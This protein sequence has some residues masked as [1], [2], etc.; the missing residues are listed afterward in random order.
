MRVSRAAVRRVRLEFRHP[1]HTARGVATVRDTVLFAL[2]DAEGHTGHGEAAPW[3][4]FG[5]E[6]VDS[7]QAALEDVAAL[8]AGL[9][10]EPDAASPAIDARLRGAPAARAALEGALWDLASR[11]AGEPLA[12]SL[13]R[14][15]Q[16]GGPGALDAVATHALLGGDTPGA[17]R[18]SAAAARAAGYR[19]AKI[20]LGLGTIDEDVSRA[21]AAREALGPQLRLR[22]DANGAWDA[23]AA[24][25]A[26]ER[27]SPFGFEFVE[28]PLPAQALD[29]LAGLRRR[30]PVRIALDE[31]VATGPE[32][33]RAV[34]AGAADVLVL[35]PAFL[36]G[37]RRALEVAAR[38]RAAGVE[39]VFTHA[40]E[41][42]VGAH[43]ALHCAA[44]AADPAAIHGLGTAGLF[45]EDVAAPVDAVR[46]MVRVP[47]SPGL[48]VMP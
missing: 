16:P 17:V 29:A 8:V 7:A 19:A 10:L 6:D 34:E 46:G 24:A 4:G 2:T 15:V 5:T 14:A 31:S 41:S 47:V 40:M 35:K 38:A 37:P 42:A 3:P 48:G 18:K 22:G 26:L 27:L 39:V 45:A 25:D 9:D 32:A 44:V 36:G 28:Q 23:H 20:K 33:L 30:A 13:A 43:V 11:R 21:R 1:V 12:R